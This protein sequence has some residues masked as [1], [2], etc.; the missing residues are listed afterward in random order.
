MKIDILFCDYDGTLAPIGV[1]RE[2]SAVPPELEKV[3]WDFAARAQVG[4]VTAKDFD[5]IR[6]RTRFAKGWA[7]VDGLEVRVGKKVM[8]LRN[9][10]DLSRALAL[11][12]SI[13]GDGLV[14]ET[15]SGAR[16]EVLGFCVDWSA[17]RRP[18]QE[19]L[20]KL[21]QLA[22]GGFPAI[23]EVEGYMDVFAQKPDKGRAVK[24]LK[25]LLGV[26]GTVMFIGD[27][28]EDNAGFREADVAVGVSHGQPLRDLECDFV[29][30]HDKLESLLGSVLRDGMEF[31]PSVPAVRGKE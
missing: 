8:T 10:A 20:S 27:S 6:P 15:K 1:R 11:A 9:L 16:G 31:S 5:F 3:L 30:N 7:C 26:E 13:K 28:T 29:V 17:G 2:Y 18:N 25:R 21:G 4:I 14:V 22:E 19:E 12:E 23:N 24:D